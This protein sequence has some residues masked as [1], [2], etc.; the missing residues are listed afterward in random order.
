MM[1][2]DARIEYGHRLMIMRL[3][4][5]ASRTEVG[6]ACGF[7]GAIANRT[8]QFW[9]HGDRMP[10]ID[11]LRPLAAVLQVPINQVVP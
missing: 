6:E 9:E 8:V 10:G 2:K 4:A 11:H 5:G 7:T 3:A 1:T